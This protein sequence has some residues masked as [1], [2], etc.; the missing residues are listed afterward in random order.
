MSSNVVPR[1]IDDSLE[2][3]RYLLRQPFFGIKSL[4]RLFRRF[5][6]VKNNQHKNFITNLKFTV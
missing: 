2:R 5:I 1:N 4:D 6:M 3:M